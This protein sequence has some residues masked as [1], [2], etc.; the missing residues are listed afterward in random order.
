MHNLKINGLIENPRWYDIKCKCDHSSVET[1]FPIA[2]CLHCQFQQQEDSIP[3]EDFIVKENDYDDDDKV[4][5]QH[6]KTINE[7]TIVRGEKYQDVI[8]WTF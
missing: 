5:G 4:I 7:I 8:G 1:E 3:L 2:D 6:D